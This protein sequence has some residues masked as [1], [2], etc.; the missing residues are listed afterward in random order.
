MAEALGVS[1]HPPQGSVVST[2]V[3]NGRLVYT[4]TDKPQGATW[5]MTL[6]ALVSVLPEPTPRR[7]VQ[8]KIRTLQ[9]ARRD[10]RVLADEPLRLGEVEARLLYLQET[11]PGGV[12]AVNGWLIYPVRGP[13]F[14]V[15]SIV[16]TA[17][18]FPRL[19][20]V[21]DAC[22]AT[23]R[24]RPPADQEDLRQQRFMLG[25]TA[26]DRFTPQHLRGALAPRSWYRMY[27]PGDSP[28]VAGDSEVGYLSI[29]ARE[30]PR[31]E[32]DPQRSA[33]S[34]GVMEAESG[35]LAL[36]EARAVI[37]AARGHF[38]DVAGRYWMSW[39][40]VR[41]GWSV[42]MTERQGPTERTSA[43]TGQREADKLT[44]INSS[45]DLRSRDPTTWSIPDK[46]YLSQV[47]VFLLGALLPRDG[48]IQG[49]MSFYYYDPRQRRMP[50]RIDDW[51]P[52]GDGTGQWVLRSQSMLE[53]A[54]HTQV[55]DSA[56]RR[57]RRIDADGKITELI[58]FAELQRIWKATGLSR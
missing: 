33:G 40:R 4:F 35:L 55:F 12:V 47:E 10:V 45:Q 53:A 15:L 57:L 48:S 2:Q 50:V 21:F 39:D 27:S 1:L 31:G 16:T 24:G 52:L 8:E 26:I 46:A 18:H 17:D 13:S 54:A 51:A 11:L 58:D 22:M 29:E 44:V 43:E 19:R 34:Y 20:P 37:D 9:E 14:L 5:T 3:T 28:G 25:R 36:I 6:Q 56:G 41:E 30:A 7:L 49:E 42:L 32:L 38:L 23:V